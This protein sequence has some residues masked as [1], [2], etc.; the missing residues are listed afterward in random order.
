MRIELELSKFL[1]LHPYFLTF[2]EVL[3]LELQSHGGVLEEFPNMWVNRE[4]IR[5][6]PIL[7]S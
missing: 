2:F 3:A 4:P 1:G 6:R 5:G 7:I